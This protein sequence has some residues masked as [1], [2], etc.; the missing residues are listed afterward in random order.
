MQKK[1]D[2][3]EFVDT[4][5]IYLDQLATCSFALMHLAN[6]HGDKSLDSAAIALG[7]GVDQLKEEFIK[8]IELFKKS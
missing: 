5:Q 6:K 4:T 8:Y 2:F 3:I 7:H 1:F